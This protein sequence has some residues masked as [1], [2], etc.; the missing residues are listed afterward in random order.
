MADWTE[1]YRPTTLTE[2]RGNN[3]ARDQ[4]QEWAQTWDDHHEAVILHGSPGVGKTSGAHALAADM[5]WSTIEL[6]ASDQRTKAEIER[7]AGSAAMNQSLTGGGR[8]LVIVDEADNIHG[9]ADRGGT[10]AITSL[11]KRAKQ[12]I[13]LI[14]NEFYEMSN[15]LRNATQEIE[16]RDVS[17]R[18]IVPVL[19]DIARKES[20]DFESDALEAIAEQNSGDLRGAIHDLQAA[21]EAGGKLTE[22]MVV[23]ADRDRTEGIFQL[24][25]AVLKDEDAQGALEFSY[26]VDET[27]DDMINWIEDNLPAV[28]TSDELPPAY[29]NLSAADRWLGRVRATQNY[30]F[31]RYASD[32]MT[33]GVAAARAEPKGGWTRFSPPSYWSK[34]GRTRSARSNRDYVAQQIATS[35]HVSMATAR[36]AI[37]PYL[38]TMIHHCKPRELTVAVAAQYE[39][40]AEHVA[41][42]TGSGKSTKKVESIVEDAAQLRAPDGDEN[43]D[44]PPTA[45][46]ENTDNNDDSTSTETDV[47]TAPADES[48]DDDDEQ[49]TGLDDFL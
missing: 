34:L 49:Q 39:L 43:A 26:S 24:L 13:V 41:L 14:A 47:A 18:S 12:P 46:Q 7:V 22:S 37:V 20:I 21:T 6:N 29:R 40:E 25:D 27:P 36:K 10:R 11:V 33:A 45:S 38:E 5:G 8:Q 9:N 32:T 2:L 3:K 42:I 1:K 19:R 16:F 48:A 23:T 30:S 15:A 4:L 28:Y 31:W 35:S 44:D 17:A